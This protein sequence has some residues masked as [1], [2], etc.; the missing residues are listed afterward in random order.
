ML[1]LL[2]TKQNKSVQC[3][4]LKTVSDLG[5]EMQVDNN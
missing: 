3:Y 5:L 1:Y 4:I 2:K